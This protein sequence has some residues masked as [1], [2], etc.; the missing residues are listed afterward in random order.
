MINLRYT[1]DAEDDLIEIKDYIS[2]E[3]NNPEAAIR[4]IT[5]IAKRIRELQSFP[6]MGLNMSS[7]IDI[8]TD[9]RYLVCGD[10]LAFYRID[11]QNISIIR[12]LNGKRD[13]LKILFGNL[14][15]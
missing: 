5:T 9:Y 13:Y 7:I 6:L 15:Y 8:E 12:V 3:L 1:P 14:S 11:E 2:E 10:Y 4:I